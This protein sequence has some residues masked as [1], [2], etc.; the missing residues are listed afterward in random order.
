[1]KDLFTKV[2]TFLYAFF[3]GFMV[4][5]GKRKGAR[6][7]MRNKAKKAKALEKIRE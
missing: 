6:G 1:M 7:A 5:D 2:F 4:A 3:L